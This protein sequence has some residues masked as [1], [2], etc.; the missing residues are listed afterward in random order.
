MSE[1]WL[2]GHLDFGLHSVGRDEVRVRVLEVHLEHCKVR[3]HLRAW[4]HK[5]IQ[6]QHLE[7]KRTELLSTRSD[8][9]CEASL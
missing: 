7:I 6:Q 2:D 5:H 4:K 3:K 1:I 8:F 9:V